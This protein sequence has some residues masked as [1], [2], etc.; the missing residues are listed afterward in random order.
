MQYIYWEPSSLKCPPIPGS[1]WTLRPHRRDR[2]SV[3]T[4]S[5]GK[6]IAMKIMAGESYVNYL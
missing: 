4:A 2:A 6:S 5:Q 1:H 3:N